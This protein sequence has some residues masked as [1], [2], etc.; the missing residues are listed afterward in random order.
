MKVGCQDWIPGTLGR[1]VATV[2]SFSRKV[3]LVTWCPRETQRA[4]GDGRILLGR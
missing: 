4:T 3:R 1:S 2:A